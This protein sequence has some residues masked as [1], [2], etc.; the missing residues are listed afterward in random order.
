MDSIGIGMAGLGTVGGGVYRNLAGNARLLANRLGCLPVLKKIAVRDLSKPRD[1]QLPAELLTADCM[2]LLDDPEIRIV[3][4]LIGGSGI[5]MDLVRGAIER[6][7]PVITGNKALLAEHGR[8][9][10][11]L[12]ASR[13][14]PI[15][16]EAAAAGGIPIIKTIREALVGNHIESMH[17]ILNG[18]SN[19]ILTRMVENGLSFGVA[20]GEASE[21]GY[22]EADPALDVNGWDAAHKA[23]ILASLAYG[24]W[25]D[26]RGV[27]VEG[28]ENVQAED[29]QFADALGYTVKLLGVVRSDGERDIEV[30]VRPTLIPR[31]HVLASVGGVFN[32]LAVRGDVV[33]DTLFYG[34]GA[35]ADPTASAVLSDVADAVGDLTSSRCA[36]SFT[37]HSLYGCC[38][39]VAEIVSPFYVRLNV[40]DKP[41][42]LARVAAEFAGRD[43]GILSVIQPESQDPERVP[44]VL[45]IHDAPYGRLMET[46]AA[47]ESLDCVRGPA[48]RMWV[49]AFARS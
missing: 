41:G 10:F 19:Y 42:V 5:A 30:T 46:L 3:I 15:Y 38:K 7:K 21:K 11:E 24:F 37:P 1:L 27:H 31:S 34:R 35:G 6:G 17:G 9:L 32:A 36:P 39:P 22:A 26:H 40:E 23:I 28:I 47:L 33:G 16:F 20:L 29:V 43:I 14:V 48:H 8:E 12:S 2:T 13:G 25:V 4:E 18:T 49:E 44:L 45:M